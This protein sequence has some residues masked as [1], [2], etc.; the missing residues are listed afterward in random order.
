[1]KAIIL[2]LIT[3]PGLII[4]IFV[5]GLFSNKTKNKLNFF[6]IALLVT[7]F[8]SM[9]ILSKLLSLPIISIAK[10]VKDETISNVDA[11]V[12]LTGGIYKD[13][14]GKWQPS[15]NTENR[16]HQAELFLKKYNVPLIISGGHTKNNAPSEAEITKIKYNLTESIIDSESLNTF[17]SARNLKDYCEDL[18]GYILVITDKYHSLRTYLSFKTQGCNILMNNYP[19][20]V[21]LK[22]F[23][24]SL[25]GFSEFNSVIYEYL[26]ILYYIGTLKINFLKLKYI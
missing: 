8:S 6:F 11:V 23:Y 2:S 26:G 1:M 18:E 15:N 24:P 4:F 20:S 9:P 10:K 5:L 13:L 7:F 12:I 3:V 22:D 17:E 14:K 21:K 16:I 19:I 25:K